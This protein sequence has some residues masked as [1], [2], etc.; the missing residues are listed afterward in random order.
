MKSHYQ[1]LGVCL[2]ATNSG[3]AVTDIIFMPRGEGVQNKVHLK[4]KT[5]DF[6]VFVEGKKELDQWR[7]DHGSIPLAQVVNGWK[8]FTSHHHG[9]SNSLSP[10]T[11][12]ELQS[13]FDSDNV[14]HVIEQVL[15]KGEFITGAAEGR[16]REV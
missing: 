10:P 12:G 5:N 9:N 15:E 8:V 4:G 6:I 16:V 1:R 3:P 2:V 14:A 13:E 11:K 7:E